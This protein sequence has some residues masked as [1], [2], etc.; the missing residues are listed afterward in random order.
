MNYQ[1]RIDR[2]ISRMAR[3][4]KSKACCPACNGDGFVLP[5]GPI[6]IGFDATCV[7]CK[8]KGKI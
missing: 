6:P 1:N 8:G 2:E 5:D 7:E 4:K 3:A